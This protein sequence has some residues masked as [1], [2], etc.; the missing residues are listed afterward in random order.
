M[1]KLKFIKEF[2]MSRRMQ[3]SMVRID[4]E[5][6]E[7]YEKRTRLARYGLEGEDRLNFQLQNVRLPLVCLSDV[8]VEYNKKSAQADFVVISKSKIFIL[9]VKNLFGNIR[10]TKDKEV[11]RVLPRRNYTEEE[12]M[13]NPFAQTRKQADTFNDL[14]KSNGYDVNIDIIIVMGNPRTAIYDNDYNL[15]IIK[16]D[17]INL[18]LKERIS[19]E[20]S[21]DEFN[22]MLEIGEF[23]KFCNKEKDYHDFGFIRKELQNR[24]NPL[25]KL[26]LE[27][28]ILYEE[29][30]EFRRKLAKLYDMPICN[31]FL[32]RDAENM[33]KVKPVTKEEFM[34]I[35]GLKEKKYLM[36]GKEIIEI[37]KKYKK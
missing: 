31:V 36:F 18:Y 34:S 30:L 15:P 24:P 29:L 6:N 5:S 19:E 12:G 2:Q 9:E 16:H 26:S 25:P 1:E 8:R 28:T 20:C 7:E 4:G 37:I 11:I 3:R 32:N 33:V 35:S 21:S 13:S 22:K 14:L 23:L 10:I 27:D 17:L